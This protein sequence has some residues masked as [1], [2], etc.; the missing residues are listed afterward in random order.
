MIVFL[1]ETTSGRLALGSEAR[2]VLDA[3]PEYVIP[4][5]VTFVADEA[6]FTPKTV[7]TTSERQKLVFRVKAQIDAAVLSDHRA[8][9]NAGLPGI[10]Y[11]R[12]DRNVPWPESLAIRLPS[13]P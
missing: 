11:V 6:Q 9:V 13:A 3:T 10:A 8:Q 4:A 12:L 7:E 1:P 5:H 2:L